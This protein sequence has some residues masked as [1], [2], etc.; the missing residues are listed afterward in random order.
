V[1]ERGGG[2][3]WRRCQRTTFCVAAFQR[4]KRGEGDFGEKTVI[5]T[6]SNS[7][8]TTSLLGVLQ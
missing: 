3:A 2:G 4:V 1:Q 7:S 5:V 6:E 8:Y